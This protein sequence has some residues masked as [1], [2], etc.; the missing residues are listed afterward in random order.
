MEREKIIIYSN[1]L[2]GINPVILT[3]SLTSDNVV[4]GV[5]TLFNDG[6]EKS[7]ISTDDIVSGSTKSKLNELLPNIDTT[8]FMNLVSYLNNDILLADGI[9]YGRITTIATDQIEYELNI[10]S[11]SP[12]KYIDFSNGSCIFYYNRKSDIRVTDAPHFIAYEGIQEEPKTLSDIFIER[13]VVSGFDNL[14]RLKQIKS[15]QELIKYGDGYFNVT[16]KATDL[17]TK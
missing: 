7:E 17:I 14:L 3:F 11:N 13:G 9:E 8:N 16:T 2:D 15:V 5:Y 6:T 4:S 12:I 1:Q 10:Y